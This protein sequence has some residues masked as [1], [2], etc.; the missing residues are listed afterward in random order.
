MKELVILQ[1][2]VPDYRK[3]MFGLL[4]EK[5]GLNFKL[6]AGDVYFEKA[7][8][9]DASITYRKL[10]KNH[11]IF[12]RKF[13]FQTGIWKEVLK[14]NIMV[15]EMNPRIISNWLL[16]LI[17]R[18]LGRK[19]VLW[20]HAWPRKGAA[21]VSDRLRNLIR[22]LGTQIIVYTKT[23]QKELQVKMPKKQIYAAP[24]SVFY[25]EEMCY[26][27]DK[28]RINNVIYVGRLT[29]GKKP[30]F[31]VE[32]FHKA[33]EGIPANSKLLII[34]EGEERQKIEKYVNEHKLSQRII[35]YG[36]VVEFNKLKEFYNSSLVSVSPGYIGLS[37]TQ[38][39]GFGVPMI[40]SK[41]ENHSP[42]IEA[43][44]PGFNSV[45][46]E[47]D[48]QESLSEELI[49]F[50]NNKEDWIRKRSE[51]C[52]FCAENYSVQVMADHFIKLAS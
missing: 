32:A 44:I 22:K 45:F 50:F 4:K 33:I 1:T 27:D 11:F 23:Q 14:D 8:K 29:A 13:L 35:I 37:I 36:H 7:I 6:Y 41:N 25:K 24:N 48:I 5:L 42:E 19:T 15:I 46:F 47:T 9:S 43:V 49:K 18:L 34:G 28:S 12:G 26:I 38:S 39:Y 21:S 16:L 30:L 10:A 51:I 20:G 2:V 31:L 40:V 3:K 52:S 17:R